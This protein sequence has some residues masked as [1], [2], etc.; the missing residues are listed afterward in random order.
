[1]MRLSILKMIQALIVLFFALSS[2]QAQSG[3]EVLDGNWYSAQWKYGYVMKNGVG[4]AT[5]TNSPNFQVGQNILQ[6]T[7]T[8]HTTFTGRQ[9]YTD[10]KFYLVQ[11]KLQA[12]GRLYFEG[13]KNA[14]WVME[15]VG[16]STPQASAQNNVT[17]APVIDTAF[18]LVN[19]SGETIFKLFI[20]PVHTTGW[21]QDVLGDDVLMTGYEQPFNPGSNRGCRFD[22]QVSYQSK[23]VEEKRNLN[24][25]ELERVI[26]DGRS[27]TLPS[28]QSSQSPAPAPRA[29]PAPAPRP[30]ASYDGSTPLRCGGNVNCRNQAEVVQKMQ[31]RWANF[32][33]STHYGNTCLDAIRTIR[34][35]HPAAYGDG[36][37]GFVQPQMDVCNLR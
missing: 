25:C 20:S 8:S 15:R 17:P 34:T 36:N 11:A 10:G 4:T 16:S 1:M 22:I 21:G 18:T 28:G 19:R 26:F 7:A 2:A 27:A 5:S 13:E 37:P 9:I 23:R 32:S 30:P 6:L 14:K 35:M 3:V 29:A 12:D 33:R 31:M 24:L